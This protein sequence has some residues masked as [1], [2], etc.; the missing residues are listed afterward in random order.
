MDTIIVI[1]DEA[2]N[3]EMLSSMIETN[4]TENTVYKYTEPEHLLSDIKKI[5]PDIAFID[6]EMPKINGLKLAEKIKELHSDV[7]VILI[8]S[9]SSYAVAAFEINAMDYI[10]KPVSYERLEKSINRYKCKKGC[11]SSILKISVF[12]KMDVHKGNKQVKW[13]GS[14][15]AELF[16]FLL[17]NIGKSIHKDEI[18]D[19]LW[20]DFEYRRASANMQ[21]AMSRIRKS[22]SK[23]G[24]EIKISYSCGYYKMK[25][26]N[27]NFDR[28]KFEQ[29][30]NSLTNIDESNY[31]K[32]IELIQLYKGDL[33]EKEGY[34]WSYNQQL[35]LK[36][37]YHRILKKLITFFIKNERI[38][39]A[40][41]LLEKIVIENINNSYAK[42]ILKKISLNNGDRV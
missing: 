30:S 22:L 16:A 20:S 36:K 40:I 9:D 32:A 6:I 18:I 19:T 24:S 8:S 28:E 41:I 25:M 1:D 42:K 13:Q 38:D 31:R 26:E 39:E 5:K 10:L 14:K 4:F 11:Q 3:V 34:I 15:N 33:F 7:G 27:V 35:I 12:G 29:L 23:I 21:T 17:H 37:I 2:V